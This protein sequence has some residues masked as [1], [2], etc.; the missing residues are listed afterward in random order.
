MERNEKQYW[1]ICKRNLD[2]QVDQGYKGLPTQNISMEPQ[3]KTKLKESL[4]KILI[5]PVDYLE[6]VKR[7]YTTY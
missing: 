2:K 6:E 4:K 5:Q 1:S 3:T 7:L